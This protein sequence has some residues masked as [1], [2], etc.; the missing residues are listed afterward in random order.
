MT[1]DAAQWVMLACDA[2]TALKARA[3]CKAAHHVLRPSCVAVFMLPVC[4]LSSILCML[5]IVAQ[6]R[7]LSAPCFGATACMSNLCL[8]I[9]G[10]C[11]G[12]TGC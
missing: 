8:S 10:L 5:C 2:S 6:V 1:F 9:A 12:I 3:Y 7:Y 11:I 4:L